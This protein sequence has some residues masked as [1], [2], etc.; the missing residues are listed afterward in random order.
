[1]GKTVIMNNTTL[2]TI[3]GVMKD[4]P[5][6]TDIPIRIALSWNSF[7]KHNSQ[8]WDETNSSSNCYVLL[9]PGQTIGRVQALIPG[10]GKE[11]FPK[12]RGFEKASIEFQPLTKMHFDTRLGTYGGNGMDPARLWALALI[13]LFL[14]LIA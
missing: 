10:F 8:A 3:T 14:L 13:G 11:N 12:Q 1:M 6:N 7:P 9:A 2:F 4:H 5:D